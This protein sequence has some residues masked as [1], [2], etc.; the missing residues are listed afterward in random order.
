MAV[1]GFHCREAASLGKEEGAE[2]TVDER[3]TKADPGAA[4]TTVVGR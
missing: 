3:A 4:L 1:L 2:L